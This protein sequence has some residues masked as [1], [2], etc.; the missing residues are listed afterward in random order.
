MSNDLNYEITCTLDG[1][2]VTNAID[3][4]R[5]ALTNQFPVDAHDMER[6]CCVD[7]LAAGAVSTFPCA[8]ISSCAPPISRP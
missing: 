5:D 3:A 7:T 4:L 2:L 8:T 6:H 1:T